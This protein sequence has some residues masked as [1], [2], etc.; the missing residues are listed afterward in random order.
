M[1]PETRWIESYE[2]PPDLP[3]EQRTPDK[4]RITRTSYE[5]S[6][7]ELAE[8]RKRQRLDNILDELDKLTARI[9]KLEKKEDRG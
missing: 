6:D 4:A 2:Y 8:E 7:E 1:T 9:E 5:V 3:P